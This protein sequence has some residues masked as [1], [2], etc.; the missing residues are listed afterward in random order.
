MM[1]MQLENK[2][3]VITGAASGIGKEIAR[4]FVQAGATVAIADHDVAAAQ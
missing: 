1:R 4:T 3:A 2:I